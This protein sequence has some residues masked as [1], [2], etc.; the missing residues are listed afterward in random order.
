MNSE[1]PNPWKRVA[2]G[3]LLAVGAV[4]VIR[5]SLM[6]LDAFRTHEPQSMEEVR[7][8]LEAGGKKEREEWERLWRESGHP[9]PPGGFDAAWRA[10]RGNAPARDVPDSPPPEQP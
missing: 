9:P 3:L 6:A 7:E 8:I 5:L 10:A 1:T 2:V 4:A